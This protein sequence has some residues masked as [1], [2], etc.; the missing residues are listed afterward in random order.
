MSS[1][2]SLWLC[3]ALG[4]ATHILK[5]AGMAVR[6]PQNALRTRREYLRLHWDVLAVRALLSAALFWLL[7]G[8]PDLLAALPAIFGAPPA[9]LPLTGATALILGYFADS[10]MDWLVSRVPALQKELPTAN[11]WQAKS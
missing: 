3:F 8:R 5:R 6:S 2:L 10:V 4:Q 9:E 11:G 1:S 7:E